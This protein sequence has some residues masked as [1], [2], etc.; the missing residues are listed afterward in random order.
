MTRD[1]EAMKKGQ[2]AHLQQIDIF[3]PEKKNADSSLTPSDPELKGFAPELAENSMQQMV[4]TNVERFG[5]PKVPKEDHLKYNPV[6][7][8]GEKPDGFTTY[9][10]RK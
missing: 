5:A 6:E 1:V 3:K 10:Q 8:D 2:K 4:D 9:W 7:I